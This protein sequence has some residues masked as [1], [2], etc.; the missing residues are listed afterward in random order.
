MDVKGIPLEYKATENFELSEMNTEHRTGV[1]AHCVYD[2]I[3]KKKDI[4]RKGMFSKSWKEFK[5]ISFLIDHKAHQRPGLV[6][7]TYEDEKKAYTKVKFSASTLG[8]DTMLMMDEGIIKGASFGF[9]ALKSNR[10]EVKGQK[11]RE[12]KEVLHDETTVT[13]SISPINDLAGI[14]KV[15]KAEMG[16]IEE[17]KL[18]LDRIESFCRNTTASDE[19]IIKLEA[20]V[21]ASREIISQYDTADTPLATEQFAS[22]TDNDSFREKL[23]LLNLQQSKHLIGA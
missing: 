1:I 20:E 14:I 23:L 17:F 6:I 15:T 21:K 18:H 8:N 3:D 2:N 11:V 22:R 4:S 12:L 13:Y 7:N 9:Y 16:A 5:G 10:I 19:T